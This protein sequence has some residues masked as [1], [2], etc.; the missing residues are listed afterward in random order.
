M[1]RCV[2][3]ACQC[4]HVLMIPYSISSA[5]LLSYEPMHANIWLAAVH[6]KQMGTRYV[7]HTCVLY[8]TDLS[9]QV[10]KNGLNIRARTPSKH[11]QEY[12]A[13]EFGALGEV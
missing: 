13:G 6:G 10:T 8:I 7:M 9:F 3:F 4:G 1:P 12:S 11:G 5:L 2:V